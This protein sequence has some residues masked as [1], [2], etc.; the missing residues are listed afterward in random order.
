M[1]N[2]PGGGYDLYL[3]VTYKSTP[4]IK[5]RRMDGLFAWPPALQGEGRGRQISEFK[6]SL[7][8]IVRSGPV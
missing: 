4:L 1:Q 3:V 5:A 2:T 8:Y 6:G 7:V